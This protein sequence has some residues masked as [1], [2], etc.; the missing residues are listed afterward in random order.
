MT[1]KWA[2]LGESWTPQFSNHVYHYSVLS[3]S[4]GEIRPWMHPH[5]I[6]F[7]PKFLLKFGVVFGFKHNLHQHLM[8]LAYTCHTL[9][10]SCACQQN[11]DTKLSGL[12]KPSKKKRENLGTCPNLNSPPPPSSDNWE[13]FD[14]QNILK[15][16]DPPHRT[17]FRTFW[18]FW[19]NLGSN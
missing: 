5:K 11:F 1:I 2:S 9:M 15:I 8:Y 18:I 16:A 10:E 12:G 4:F 14:F 7:S 19:K 3:K 13:L 6:F 17:N